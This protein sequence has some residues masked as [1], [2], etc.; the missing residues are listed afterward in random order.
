MK[1]IFKSLLLCIVI[2]ISTL[3]FNYAQTS[4]LV[5]L[6][7]QGKLVYNAD[8]KGNKVPDYSGIGYKNSESIIP[9][10]QV[11]KT[12]NAIVGDN[13]SNIQSAINDV[14]AM[15]IDA[16]G[17]RGAILFKAGTYNISD[18]INITASGIVLRGEGSGTHLIAT[19]T[20]QFDL[21]NFKGALSTGISSSSI[22]A[23]TDTY[24]PIGTKQVTV[25]AG[26]TF[27]V[28]DKVFF[29]RIPNQAWISL[30]K[31]D[32]LTTLP[33][34]DGTTTNWQAAD[35]DIYYERKVVAVSGNLI[36]LDAPV[37][38]MIDPTYATAEL[39]KFNDYRI[40][41]CGIE[42][43]KISSTYASS[44]DEN[45]GWSAI[46]FNNITNSWAKNIDVYYFGYSA[47]EIQSKASFITVDA[48]KMLDA[49][50]TID[51]GRRY[52]FEI[53]GQRSL[54]QNC[55]T[56]NGRHDYVNGSRTAGPN[57]FY[58]CNATQQINDI[59]PHHRWATGILFD[60]ITGNG[61]MNVQNRTVSGSGHGWAGSQ[62]MYWNCKGNRMA[63]QDPQGDHVNW[64]VGFIGTITNVGDMTTEPLGIVESNGINIV[65]IP[66]LFKAQ[67][68]ERLLSASLPVSSDLIFNSSTT[69]TCPSGVNSVEVECWGA[70]GSG[71]T[72]TGTLGRAGGGG[73]GGSYVKNVV[74]VTPGVVYTITVGIGGVAGATLSANCSGKQGG[75]TEFSGPSITA[76]TASG[77]AAGTGANSH[78]GGGVG[79]ILGGIYGISIANVGSGYSGTPTATISGGGGN[80]VTSKISISSG[81]LSFITALSQGSGYTSVPTVA[82]IGNGINGT[83]T[84]LVSLDL[85]A[86]GSIITKGVDGNDGVFAS[87]SGA[88][89]DGANGGSG[90]DALAVEALG[91]AG[92]APGGGGSGGYSSGNSKVGGVGANGQIKITYLT[93]LPV[94]LTSF[95]AQKQASGV[96]LK[97]N[98]LS[99]KNN[100]HFDIQRSTD[101]VQF[102]NIGKVNGSGNSSASLAYY[103]I[104]KSPASGINY[105]QL[106]QVDFDGKTSLSNPVSVNT[107]F[108]NSTIHVFSIPHSTNLNI[109]ISL[110]QASSGQLAIYDLNGRKVFQQ[111]VT[112][113]KG[114]ND[115]VISMLN[116]DKGVLIATYS[117]DLQLLKK[118]FIR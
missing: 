14:A 108:I 28:N 17:F 115:F 5:S 70:G 62:I 12:V 100:S 42:Y 104:D 77:G 72:A 105:Y 85:D 48:C 96:Q 63:I 16:N 64:S 7:G 81:A 2:T 39:M 87:N 59:G 110:E 83:A 35:Y 66:S 65:A 92:V 76:V 51:G 79:G 89:G 114:N 40:E 10:I 73:G 107:G 61:N 111:A 54:V 41:K 82:I 44:T 45:H 34:A 117:D 24:V 22:K 23:I 33:G 8:A 53:T 84:A 90:G 99:E 112:L 75:K 94:S 93:T 97:W 19:K 3:S 71:G 32:I 118:K 26:H 91:I 88:G 102:L 25:V 9:T 30:L 1:Q 20:S 98:T 57:V 116:A 13:L 6:D 49:K 78:N 46:V 86:G 80:G 18:A 4:S 58:N 47:V 21:I 52:S 67:L 36:T 68:N 27:T 50:S 43:M 15:P 31:M 29:H 69:W 113:N 38:D 106:S 95:T 101:G 37:M 74:S 109:N 60:K 103:F 56:R 55:V 11:V